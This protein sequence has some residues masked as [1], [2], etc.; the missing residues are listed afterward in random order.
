MI[1]ISVISRISPLSR[2]IAILMIVVFHFFDSFTKLDHSMFPTI[3]YKMTHFGSQGIHFFFFI[4]AF[5]LFLKYKDIDAYNKNFFNW[6]K[7]RIIKLYSTYLAS[8]IVVS[9][10]MFFFLDI[11]VSMK[12]VIINIIP[13]ARNFDDLYIHSL[14]GNFWFLHT[15]IEF[16]LVFPIFMKVYFLMTRLK[17][18]IMTYIVVIIYISWYSFYLSIDSASLNPYS[19]FFINYLYDFSL[20][21]AFASLLER[22][23]SI[24]INKYHLLI[25]FVLFEI[26]GFIMSQMGAFGRNTNDMFFSIGSIIFIL[27]VAYIL[28]NFL[29]KI[30]SQSSVV[31][32]LIQF[33]EERV[34]D[35]YLTHH[36][37]IK[38][39]FYNVS[40]FSYIM[41]FMLFIVIFPLSQIN[42]I[43]SN[44]IQKGFN[45]W[46][47]R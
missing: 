18:L 43:L 17:F 30:N 9:F 3:I 42:N 33:F 27:S 8:V 4:S 44:Y 32:K 35:I 25:I 6:L 40:S 24:T 11:N 20:G 5:F 16:Y 31:S 39:L 26:I 36:P 23:K 13:M 10:L 37:I 2:V 47:I 1:S 19:A 12:E 28:F 45:L 29:K 7:V 22:K 14:N 41:L 46:K 21:I 15:L 38:V 34:Y